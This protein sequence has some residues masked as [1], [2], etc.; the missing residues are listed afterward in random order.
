MVTI[1]SSSG[2]RVYKTLI[3]DSTPS[4][5]D[6]YSE[7]N[8]KKRIDL[9]RVEGKL[10]KKTLDELQ[11]DND[12]E[13]ARKSMVK[14]KSFP[15]PK[16]AGVKGS[17]I[18]NRL[19]VDKY[20]PTSFHELLSDDKMNREILS[21]LKQWDPIVFGKVPTVKVA[22]KK[23]PFPQFY[24][25]NLKFSH[26]V[27]NNSGAPAQKIILLT[28]GPGLGKTTL[29]HILS[30]QAGYNPV[31]INASDDRS[32]EQFETKFLAAIEM[33]SVFGDQ[34]PN[35]LIIDEIDGISGRDNGPIELI[36]KLL[37]NDRKARSGDK[38][39]GDKEKED[40]EGGGSGDKKKKT[41]PKLSRPIICICND[42][43][44]PSLRKLRDEALL[45]NFH[46]PNHQRLLSR[47]REIC[48]A[49][50]FKTDDTA[51]SMLI[52]STGYDIRSCLN[53][54]QFI[55][56]KSSELNTT[57]LKDKSVS[58]VIGQKDMEKGLFE[59][60]K[61]VFS[62]SSND[63]KSS[64]TNSAQDNEREYFERLEQQVNSCNQLD[65]LIE[66]LYENFTQ[67]IYNDYTFD[68]T[69][70]CLD[71]FIYA[72]S[73]SDDDY[74]S[75]TP[76][77]IHTR[78]ANVS[79]K[80]VFPRSDYENFVKTKNSMHTID[81]FLLSDA[82]SPQIYS[83]ITRTNFVKDFISPF[84]D[85][86]SVPVR[87]VNPQL[88]SAREKSILNNLCGIMKHFNLRYDTVTTDST[89]QY[90]LSP[91]I[92]TSKHITLTNTQKQII[93]GAKPINT[94]KVPV[95]T[96]KVVLPV[97]PQKDFFGRT[98]QLSPDQQK[99]KDAKEKVPNIRYR[100]QEGFTNAVK[101]IAYMKDFL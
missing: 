1:T 87:S 31:E 65:K 36:L 53:S 94:F 74:K 3:K 15:L 14:P 27:A 96:P 73:M 25:K 50:G 75:L 30:K 60:W 101:K 49:E 100:Y 13:D 71:W 28:G 17:T 18:D 32:G 12:T 7:E 34:R 55:K 58:S 83:S 26:V 86:I 61:S 90:V 89:L 69:V 44:V 37:A 64:L 43:F 24:Q 19:W 81:S 8:I 88:Y 46:Q 54:L 59:L 76:L 10:L 91:D 79:P 77:A 52:K 99:T 48:Q 20:T 33:K 40:E 35:C 82:V 68:K 4:D 5:A 39:D 97:E 57:I 72:D 85:I 93:S 95:S 41:L 51:L 78:C 70:S 16:S 29:A 47:L 6:Y 80:T 38:T 84:V 98:I 11:L 62:S 22:E 9:N 23:D 92:K 67:N 2:K 63:T 21:W 45:F 66:G 42:Q 56:T